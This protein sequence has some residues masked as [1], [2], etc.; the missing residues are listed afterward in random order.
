MASAPIA[1]TAGLQLQDL[2]NVLI[3][4]LTHQDPFKPVDN[5]DFMAQIAQFASLDANQQVNQNILQLLS[6]QAL[7]QSVAL[8]GKV[9]TAATGSG[10]V[11]GK[12][13]AVTISNG[14]PRLTITELN[15][16]R[17]VADV[18]IGELQRILPEPAVPSGSQP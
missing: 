11:T 3:T 2:L 17:V 16:N 10:N 1:P 6:V 15:S 12:V 7:N 8:I 18:A 9:V 14:A 5:K 4:E 13:T